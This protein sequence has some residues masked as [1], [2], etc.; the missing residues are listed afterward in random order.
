[1][2]EQDAVE[3]DRYLADLARSAEVEPDPRLLDV[4]E[5]L[6]QEIRK[7][8]AA[9]EENLKTLVALETALEAVTSNILSGKFTQDAVDGGMLMMA[10][11]IIRAVGLSLQA[12][13][14]DGLELSESTGFTDGVRLCLRAIHRTMDEKFP[15]MYPPPPAA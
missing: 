9:D 4:A 2:A 12:V 11:E 6:S 7:T 15:G 13:A 10:V 5:I 8:A 14:E 1:M 3:R